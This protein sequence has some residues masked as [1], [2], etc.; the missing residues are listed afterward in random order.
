MPPLFRSMMDA[1]LT[2]D[3]YLL[4]TAVAF[5][6]GIIAAAGAL[7]HGRSERPTRSFLISLVILPPIVETVILMVNGNV[8]T[9][10]AVAGAFSLIRFRSAPGSARD[11]AHIFLAMTAG[12]VCSTGYVALAL[13]F[14]LVVAAVTVGLSFVPMFGDREQDLR[15]TIPETLNFDGAFDDLLRE[16]TVSWRLKSV[17]TA[18]MGTLYKL[19]YKVRLRDP[20]KAKELMDKIRCR[21]GNLEVA[22]SEAAPDLEAL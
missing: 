9:G 18:A 2:L 4:C 11:I 6:C 12:I 8:G 21:N 14:S 22:L 15:I 16:Y 1:D 3:S 10:I 17:K 5:L 13:L 19:H 20:R 7:V